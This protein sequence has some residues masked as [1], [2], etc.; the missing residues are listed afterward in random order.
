MI[1]CEGAT[2]SGKTHATNHAFCRYVLENIRKDHAIVSYTVGTAMRNVVE[3]CMAFFDDWGWSPV[4][5]YAPLLHIAVGESKVFILSANTK[6]SVKG[7]QGMTL[8]GALCDEVTNIH[9]DVWNMLMSRMTFGDSKIW[10]T[11]NPDLPQ[12]W[13]KRTIIDRLAE[14]SEHNRHIVFTLDD[15]PSL[16][17]QAKARMRAALP[18][19][20]RQRL[21]EGMWIAPS[22]NIFPE[23][24]V[25]L[26]AA[27]GIRYYALDWGPASVT[28]CLEIIMS[29]ARAYV[30]RELYLRHNPAADM[31]EQALVSMILEFAVDYATFYVDPSAP[32]G[33]KQTLQA[34]GHATINAR[35][36]LM[37][38]IFRTDVMLTKRKIVISPDCVELIREL[39]EYTWDA[40]KQER[41]IS[42][43]AA[44]N[45]HAVDALRYF[46]ASMS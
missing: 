33:V 45:D 17:D 5:K 39:N 36:D 31:T 6:R 21:L 30:S 13:F 27:D 26:S 35:N 40:D 3:D 44:V 25:V 41:G 1:I 37:D 15:N 7:L 12:H 34:N 9:R 29:S 8:A 10:A 23:Y 2:R 46:C 19:R 24:G 4:L 18:H 11:L 43:P 14:I 20:W 32:A 28:A 22:G 38:G 16:S 42:R